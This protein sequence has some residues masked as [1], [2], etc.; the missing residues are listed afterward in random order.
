MIWLLLHPTH[1]YF[2]T[3]K[4]V[5]YRTD[6]KVRKYLIFNCSMKVISFFLCNINLI[7]LLIC[8]QCE[9][10]NGRDWNCVDK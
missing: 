7:N 3:V 9:D 4:N 6:E 10:E 2:E 1:V 5:K 8:M